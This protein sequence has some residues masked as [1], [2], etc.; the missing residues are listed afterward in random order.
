MSAVFRTT[1]VSARLILRRMRIM[2]LILTVDEYE[3]IRLIDLEGLTQE[4]CAAQMAIARTTVQGIY[5]EA[6]KLAQSLVYGKILWIE[7][8][9]YG[10]VTGWQR[11]R[12][13]RLPQ[14]QMPQGYD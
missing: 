8:G 4:Q 10:S 6:R 1:A 5:N 12:R 3:T 7:G 14:T 13:R 11:M 2:P 9:E